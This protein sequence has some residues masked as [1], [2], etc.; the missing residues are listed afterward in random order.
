MV[1]LGSHCQ[2]NLMMSLLN[3]HLRVPPM[4]DKVLY[5]GH[6]IPI[7]FPGEIL[8]PIVEQGTNTH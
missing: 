5:G 6:V 1:E 7:I 3:L 4:V 2:L 8:S